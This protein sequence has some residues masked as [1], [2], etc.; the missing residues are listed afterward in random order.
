MKPFRPWDVVPLPTKDRVF[1]FATAEGRIAEIMRTRITPV[2]FPKIVG[3]EAVRD[4][5]FRTVSQITLNDRRMGLSAGAAGH[6]HGG[7]RLPWVRNGG[8]DNFAPLATMTWQVHV[9]GAVSTELSGWCAD[10]GVPLYVFDW[11]SE[12][13]AAGL[14]R[15]ALYLLRPDTYIALADATGRPAAL[16]HYCA[17]RGIT[18][19]AQSAAA[20]GT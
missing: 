8:V 15:D 3:F 6:V 1:T 18:F 12:H 11:K 14:A 19:S 5:I 10:H 2:I 13:E 17:E 20:G 16:D 4:Y 7:D 9:Y